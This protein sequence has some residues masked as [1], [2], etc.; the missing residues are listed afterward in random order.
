MR[1]LNPHD[2]NWA[3]RC[4]PVRLRNQ[5]LTCGPKLVLGG[6][7]VRS[8]VQGEKPND[9]DL[10]THSADDAK[11]FAKE[12]ADGVKKKPYETGNA[13]SV[14]LSPRHFVQYIH[15]WSFP[16]PEYLLESFDFTIACAAIWFDSGKWRSL[17]D[18][19]F[20]PDLAAKRLVYRSPQRNEDAGGSMLRVLKF[21]Q[22]GFR[23]PIDSLGAVLARLVNAVDY[24]GVEVIEGHG[25]SI[26]GD[27]TEKRWAKILT[28]LLH[29]V[30]PQVDPD[31]FSHL[32]IIP[33]KTEE[34]ENGN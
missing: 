21:Y 8:M 20:Y 10:F 14:K 29:E 17:I 33:T 15:R 22:R 3:V 28:G 7:Y 26:I 25:D 11:A 16:T 31:H 18:D 23:I 24:K 9:L 5:M 6:G 4:L 32:P 1:E 13:L 2:L 27:T 30:D 12:L 19:E 34:E